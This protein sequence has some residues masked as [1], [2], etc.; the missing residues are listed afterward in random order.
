MIYTLTLNPALDKQLTV[1]AISRNTVLRASETKADLGGKGFNISRM[2]ISLGTPSIAIAYLGGHTGI[3]LEEGLQALGI[4]TEAIRVA[5]ETRTNIS[6][7]DADYGSY[8]K[9]NEAGPTISDSARSQLL[10][11]IEER[12]KPGTWWTLSGSLPPGLPKE[13]YA[14][15]TQLLTKHGANVIVDASGPALTSAL[16]GK[17]FLVKPNLSEL[18]G[19]SD[20]LLDNH[21]AIAAAA[22]KLRQNGAQNVVVSLGKDGALVVS[23]QGKFHIASPTISE[24]NPIGAGDSMVAGIVQKLAEGAMLSEAVGWGVACGAA[25]ASQPGTTVG[26]RAQV[27]ALFAEVNLVSHQSS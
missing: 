13:F 8:I 20:S 16:P 2:L 14:T 18:E 9:V 11:H 10:K 25:T 17:P 27:E 21:Q 5:E 3:K 1:P 19:L 6:I 24:K 7:V 22:Q 15:L 26:S 23:E 12:A 4:E